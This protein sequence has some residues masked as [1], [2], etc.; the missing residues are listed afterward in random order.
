VATSFITTIT[1]A[2]SRKSPSRLTHQP[3]SRSFAAWVFDYDN[4][5][6]PDLFAVSFFFSVDETLC[7]YLGLPHNLET[8]KLYK[9]L[10]NGTFK[11]VTKEV[12]LDKITMPM[13]TNF[14][15]V[16]ND[17]F[18]DIYLRNGGPAYGTLVPHMLLRNNEGKS[19]VDIS[20]SSGIG[21]L[22][23]GHG[24]AFADLGNNGHEDIL[25][26]SGGATPGDAHAFRVFESLGNGND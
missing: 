19:F 6:W 12:G 15:D 2:P 24:V 3:Q 11:D 13:G 4:D 22:H 25:A 5:G 21:E 23:N 8:L 18:L 14:G 17:R 1:T 26:G 9:N 7:S 16:D 10:G 20:A